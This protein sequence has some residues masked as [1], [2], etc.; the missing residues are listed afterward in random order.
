MR[1][2]RRKKTFAGMEGAGKRRYFFPAAARI[3]GK[4]PEVR[5]K[6]EKISRPRKT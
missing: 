5:L 4:N 3:A 6:Y 1:I 2:I